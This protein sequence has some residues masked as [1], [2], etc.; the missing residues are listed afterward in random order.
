[1]RRCLFTVAILIIGILRALGADAVAIGDSF[2]F[3]AINGL[4]LDNY[5]PARLQTI[6]AAN[7][8]TI[9]FNN[10]GQSGAG[11]GVALARAKALARPTNPVLGT[12]YIGNND[13]NSS[14]IGTVQASPTSRTFSVETGKGSAFTAGAWV[15]V[16]SNQA[17]QIRSVSSDSITLETP[18]VF[19]PTAGDQVRL[20][21]FNNI[22]AISNVLNGLGFTKQVV[23]V[24]HYMNFPPGNG[25]D[26]VTVES[27]GQ[28]PSPRLYQRQAGQYLAGAIGAQTADFYFCMRQRIILGQDT[29]GSA[30]WQ[31]DLT[32]THLNSY[33]EGIL[34]GCVSAV[35]PATWYQLF[36]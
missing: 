33:G 9:T 28:F 14:N 26:T 12:I 24:N 4:G 16:G 21:T 35:I 15:F 20:D 10:Q 27:S 29:Q 34:A 17:R 5:W 25:G 7:G 31:L 22:L 13:F 19:S 23:G 18:L 6:I 11:T 32:N 30:S 3:A 36:N 1:M 2:T 8:G